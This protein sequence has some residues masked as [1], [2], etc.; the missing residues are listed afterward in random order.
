MSDSESDTRDFDNGLDDELM[1][2]EEDRKRLEM[3]ND[4]NHV[5]DI[6]A[7]VERKKMLKKH[8]KIKKK[9]KIQKRKSKEE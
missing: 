9:L 5:E 6:F 2:D 1:G 4:K 8:Y 3:M 7:S